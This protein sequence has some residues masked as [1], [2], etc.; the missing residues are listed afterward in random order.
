MITEANDHNFDKEVMQIRNTKVIVYF[1]APWCVP[2]K[3][4]LPT[5]E[6]VSSEGIANFVK[7]NIDECPDIADRYKIASVPTFIMF[8]NGEMI[9]ARPG[10][11]NREQLKSWIII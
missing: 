8:Y 9:D 11:L 2:C 1:C 4:I 5:L 3:Q 6:K 10:S 7:V